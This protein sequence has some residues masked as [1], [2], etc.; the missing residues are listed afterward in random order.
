VISIAQNG[1]IIL[2]HDAGGDRTSTVQALRTLISQLK[3]QGYEL[4]TVNQL[5]G[6]PAYK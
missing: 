6:K 2:M 1:S 4:V 3:S 5:L